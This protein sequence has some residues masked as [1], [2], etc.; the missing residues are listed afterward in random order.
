M[1]RGGARPVY[2][3]GDDMTVTVRKVETDTDFRA[4]FEFPWKL[5]RDDP[6]WVPTLLSIRRKLLDQQRNP[7]WD[8]MEGDYFIAWRDGEPVGTI[9]AHVNHRHNDFHDE[10]VGW[11]GMFEVIDDQAVANALLGTAADWVRSRGLPVL[12]GP[13]SFTTNE[14]CGLL[15]DGFTR[16]VLLMPYNYPYYQQL[17]EAAG[18]HKAM[19]TYSFHQT[20]SGARALGLHDRLERLTQAIMKR[21]RITVRPV[22]P[23][24]LKREFDLFKDLYNDAWGHAWGFVPMTPA[25]LDAM[26]AGLGQ[27]FDPRLAYFGY[28]DGE[29]VG[30]SLPVP[31][32]NQVLARAYPRPGEP[33]FVTLLKALWYWKGR[34]VIDWARVPLLGVRRAYHG[35]GVDAVLYYHSMNAII[36]SGIEHCD[37]GWVLETN[38]ELIKILEA[39]MG[40]ER[41]KTYRF[42]EQTV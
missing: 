19:D 28:V 12:R 15:V 25:E 31:D 14:E 21:N 20:A 7:S 1:N 33:E 22:N 23:R 4:F 38:V 8:Y 26:V 27:F 29:P 41:Y 32:F 13:Q 42:Y 17:I 39:S 16:P 35:R 37:C 6:N 36:D 24:D 5:Y 18:F 11:F 10:Q 30:F 9:T 2:D 34:R 40:C 3:E